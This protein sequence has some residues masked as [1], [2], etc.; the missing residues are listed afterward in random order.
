MPP[1]ISCQ[2]I[3]AILEAYVPSVDKE[4][5]ASV[6]IV[7]GSA[8]VHALPPNRSKTFEDYAALDFLPVVHMYTSQGHHDATCGS[9]H[10]PM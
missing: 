5:E 6:L 10:R 8:L 1:C 4:P 7:D 2:D 9:E 3:L